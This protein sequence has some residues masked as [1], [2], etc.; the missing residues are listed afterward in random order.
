MGQIYSKAQLVLV[1]LG[2]DFR[3]EGA[4]FSEMIHQLANQTVHNPN[5]MSGTPLDLNDPK[6]LS[7]LGLDTWQQSQWLT[8]GL[9]LSRRWFRRLWC[10]QEVLLARDMRAVCVLLGETMISWPIFSLAS[11]FMLDHQFQMALSILVGNASGKMD[12]PVMPG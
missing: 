5:C 12:L 2:S 11:A 7:F 3:S 4:S 10:L 6:S 1:W 8:L 9:Y